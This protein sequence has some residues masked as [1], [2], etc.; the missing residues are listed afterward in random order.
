MS[1][2]EINKVEAA[3]KAMCKSWGYIWDGDPAV[4]DQV[5]ARTPDEAV[6]YCRPCLDDFRAAARAALEVAAK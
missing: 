1:D 2:I 3:A 4:D 6:I 5:A